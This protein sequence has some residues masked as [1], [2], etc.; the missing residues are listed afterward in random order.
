MCS[1]HPEN[2]AKGNGK[3]CV[4]TTF[5]PAATSPS[6]LSFLFFLSLPLLLP[7]PSLLLLQLLSLHFYFSVSYIYTSFIATKIKRSAISM[8]CAVLSH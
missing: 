1:R 6:A 2:T 3:H 4:F 8:C 5:P 7:P